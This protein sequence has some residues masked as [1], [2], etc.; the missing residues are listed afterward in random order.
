MRITVTLE[1]GDI[2]LATLLLSSSWHKKG[3]STGS[4]PVGHFLLAA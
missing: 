3:W 1:P 2:V 4:L